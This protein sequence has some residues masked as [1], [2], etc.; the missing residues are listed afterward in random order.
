[1]SPCIEGKIPIYVRNV[2]NPAHP[3][4][5]IQ[6]RA[7]SLSDSFSDWRAEADAAREMSRK[8]VCPVKLTE[9]ESPIRGITSIDNVGRVRV[10]R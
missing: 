5:V 3:G 1:M 10:V 7:C 6:G 4:T 8:A 9:D 2:F